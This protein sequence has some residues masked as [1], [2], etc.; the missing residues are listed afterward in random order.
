MIVP[1]CLGGKDRHAVITTGYSYA[2]RTGALLWELGC[3]CSHKYVGT[4]V[5]VR[6]ASNVVAWSKSW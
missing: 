2:V 5:R 4:Q 3:W 6:Y 1:S